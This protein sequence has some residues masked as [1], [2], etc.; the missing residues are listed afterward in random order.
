LNPATTID[1]LGLELLVVMSFYFLFTCYL[2]LFYSIYRF[3]SRVSMYVT[4]ENDND[5]V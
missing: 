5:N 1:D 2:Q 3:D 4:E